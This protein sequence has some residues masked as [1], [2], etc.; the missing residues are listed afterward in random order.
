MAFLLFSY[1]SFHRII[2]SSQFFGI[3]AGCRSI[4][5]KK[6]L[7]TCCIKRTWDQ[8]NLSGSGQ[9]CA[10]VSS[11]G[12]RRK[13]TWTWLLFASIPFVLTGWSHIH[14][15]FTC[16]CLENTLCFSQCPVW[17][18]IL[19]TTTISLWQWVLKFY[20]PA[21]CRVSLFDLEILNC[22]FLYMW[23]KSWPVLL[24]SNASVA[25]YPWSD[26]KMSFC[27]NI[28]SVFVFWMR[29]WHAAPTL[30]GSTN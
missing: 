11:R 28:F 29:L 27:T 1:F 22:R 4:G 21:V 9:C 6:I 17:T 19:S 14:L 5:R 13:N 30:C 25:S 24:L 15:F 8:R 26:L 23:L 10:S 20:N 3:I 7:I 12:K 16:S 2:L 18:L